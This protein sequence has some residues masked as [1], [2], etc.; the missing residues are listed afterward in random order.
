MKA[1]ARRGDGESW[2]RSRELCL[3]ETAWGWA[4]IA[5]S[6]PGTL[7]LGPTHAELLLIYGFRKNGTFSYPQHSWPSAFNL[8]FWIKNFLLA[9]TLGCYKLRWGR[10]GAAGC[11][12]GWGLVCVLPLEGAAL[13]H[14]GAEPDRCQSPAVTSPGKGATGCQH[15]Q[16]CVITRCWQEKGKE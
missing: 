7:G 16:E 11:C 6:Q 9:M 12:S 10:N 15:R 1:S 3:G 4:P 8:H 14:G 13:P 5:K 2:A